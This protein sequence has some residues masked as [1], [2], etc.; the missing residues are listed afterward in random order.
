V[1]G[2]RTLTIFSRAPVAG[3]PRTIDAAA[4]TSAY[5]QTPVPDF[6][7]R[8]L[9]SGVVPQRASDAAWQAGFGLRGF[10]LDRS[11]LGP[12]GV[13]FLTLYWRASRP[14]PAGYRPALQI[15]DASGA[16]V[17]E[18]AS[19]CS[20]MPS[21]AWLTTYV[22]DAPFVIRADGLPPGAYRLAVAVRDSAGNLLPLDDATTARDLGE[23]TGGRLG[24]GA[25]TAPP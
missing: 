18:A 1:D 10:D 4:Y 23:I 9:L 22:S 7:L 16:V 13:A 20:A 15:R 6:P 2:E 21:D 12:G 8:R 11:Q 24:R 5:D 14:Q 17:A 19:V 3:P 25:P